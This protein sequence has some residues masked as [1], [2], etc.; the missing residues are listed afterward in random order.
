MSDPLQPGSV[1][2]SAPRWFKA[3]PDPTDVSLLQLVLHLNHLQAVL[4][5]SDL[6]PQLPLH[7]L[8]LLLVSP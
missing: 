5:L 8:Q 2:S 4:P 3:F 6:L 7:S 1:V